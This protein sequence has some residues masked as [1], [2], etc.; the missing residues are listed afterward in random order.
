MGMEIIKGYKKGRAV[1]F[2]DVLDPLENKTLEKVSKAEI[3][4]MCNNG[5]ITNAKIQI[6]E[7][8]PIV[9]VSSSNLPL[10]KIDENGN[11]TGVAQK[12][13]RSASA[14]HKKVEKH[15]EPIIS[16]A[17]Q[18]VQVGKL[19]NKRRVKENTSFAGYD[20]K[21]ILEQQEMRKSLNFSNIET[22]EE[23]FDEIAKDFGVKNKELY[24]KEI[25][26]K[27][28][29]DKEIKGFPSIQLQSIQ[30][31]IATYLMNMAHNEINEVYS[32]YM[33]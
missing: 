33:R 20:Y 2:Y 15:E 24:K 9:R 1:M 30:Y 19:S 29:L 23:L 14:T 28:K 27:L 6:W 18:G 13:T 7:G 25:S 17:D 21:N 26:K 11:V 12:E 3:V 16:V 22:I 8:K 32:K 5:Q 31:N 10:V 4:Q